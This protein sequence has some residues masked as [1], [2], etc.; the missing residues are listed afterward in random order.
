MNLILLIE[1]DPDLRETLLELLE[2]EGYQVDVA[3]DGEEGLRILQGMD[4][5]PG[6]VLVDWMMPKMGGEEFCAMKSK[7]PELTGLP[8]VILT[9]DSAVSDKAKQ[10]GASM[11]VAKPVDIEKLLSVVRHF[12]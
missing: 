4:P 12:L 10:A 3:R 9:A 5:K 11:G 2:L 1:D 8:V 6:L 7:N